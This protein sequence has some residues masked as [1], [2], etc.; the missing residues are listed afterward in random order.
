[1]S[2]V[3]ST[4]FKLKSYYASHTNNSIPSTNKP[5]FVKLFYDAQLSIYKSNKADVY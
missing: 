3:K 5:Y 4:Q 2:I 1:M